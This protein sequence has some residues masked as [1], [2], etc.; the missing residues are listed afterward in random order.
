MSKKLTLLTLTLLSIGTLLL[1]A[2]GSSANKTP[3]PDA[4]LVITQAAQTVAVQ[5]TLNAALTP[6]P[7][8]TVQP[9]STPVPAT[10]TQAVQAPPP[11]AATNTIAP[12]ALPTSAQ[13]NAAFVTDVTV[14]DG[15]G[16]TPGITFKKTWRIKNTGVSTWTESYALIWVDG[17]KMG[18]P[19]SVKM[20]KSVNP[21]EEV[22]ITADLTAPTKPG[23]YTSYFRLRNASG[24]TFKMDG[25]GDLWV[26]IVV[27][28][29]SITPDLT[30][31]ATVTP[32]TPTV[33]STPK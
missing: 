15:T 25:T 32:A 16:A 27:G 3:T 9:S 28:G 20:P 12:K 7:T 5:L 6:S 18:F 21:G 10:A 33:T 26:K 2:C 17:E 31:T 19:D 13:D 30:G 24:Q 14:P 22:D 4:N 29:A 1:A 23:S 8:H 11:A